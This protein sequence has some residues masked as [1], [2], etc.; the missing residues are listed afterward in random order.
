MLWGTDYSRLT[1]PYREA[2]R[3]FTDGLDSLSKDDRE[4]ILGRALRRVGRLARVRRAGNAIA[5]RR[6]GPLG[7]TV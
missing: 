3:L 6:S 7:G 4:W 2:V 5:L 1:V